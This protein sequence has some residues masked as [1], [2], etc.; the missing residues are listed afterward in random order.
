MN[1]HQRH[2]QGH[3]Q[4]QQVDPGLF[5]DHIDQRNEQDESHLEEHGDAR[6]ESDEHHGP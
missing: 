5:R 2:G 6:N 4:V 3:A 1:G